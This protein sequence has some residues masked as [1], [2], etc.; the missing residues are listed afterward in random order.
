MGSASSTKNGQWSENMGCDH[1]DQNTKVKKMEWKQVDTA[2]PAKFT[3]PSLTVMGP[4][5]SHSSKNLNSEVGGLECIEVSYM[6]FE[7]II[8]L[9]INKLTFGLYR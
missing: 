9:D 8:N 4:C 5:V 2:K 3:I 6:T 1:F 7:F